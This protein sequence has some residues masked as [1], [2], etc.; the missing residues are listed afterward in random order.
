MPRRSK[1]TRHR[2]A[3]L[4]V[5]AALLAAC[6]SEALPEECVDEIRAAS[7][8]LSHD[9][10]AQMNG[11]MMNGLFL[12]G[13]AVN[14]LM[15]NGLMMNG[16]LLEG[17]VVNGVGLVSAQNQAGEVIESFSIQGED[18]ALR[19]VVGGEERGG[20]EAF[21]VVLTYENDQGQRSRLWIERAINL[22]QS[23]YLGGMLDHYELAY[24]VE[25]DGA[26]SE[27]HTDVCVNGAGESVPV[28]L[29]NGEWDYETGAWISEDPE[30]IT[31]ACREAAIAKCIEWS[32]REQY[33]ERG[34]SH[35]ACTRMVR[36]DYAGDGTP[37]TLNGTRIYVGDPFGYNDHQHSHPGW[38]V[39]EAEWTP[40]G[41]SCINR[42][43]LR[44]LGETDCASDPD[45]FPGVPECENTDILEPSSDTVLVTATSRTPFGTPDYLYG[46]Q[47]DEAAGASTLFMAAQDGSSYELIGTLTVAETVDAPKLPVEV[48]GLYQTDF[49]GL[50]GFQIDR[51][52]G[53]SRAVIVNGNATA[54]PRGKWHPDREFRAAA[55]SSSNGRRLAF[56]I[57]PNTDELC[58]IWALDGNIASSEGGCTTLPEDIADD[59]DLVET[60]EGGEFT[61]I[62]GG[63]VWTMDVEGAT[64][65][66]VA[67]LEASV[68]GIA[69]TA[70]AGLVG[71]DATGSQLVDLVVSESCGLAAG[72]PLVDVVPGALGDL[73]GS[74]P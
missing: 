52:R 43:G 17:G 24:E 49:E 50:M 48:D 9:N 21:P 13:V 46:V 33:G 18:R 47:Y 20:P 59:V 35:Q 31:M 26:W 45:C 69:R 29:V 12:N 8:R 61:V 6:G 65:Q 44:Q 68:V 73:A 38:L 37:H 32:Y 4:G 57:A 41:A 25:Q 28:L 2:A 74:A 22:G 72:A 16:A 66:R 58:R 60:G 67:T 19:Y 70:D 51:E 56:A 54:R 15:M 53:Q 64:L 3:V 7:F 55:I 40:D 39:K 71:L 1:M 63:R 11:L 27:K 14:G 30:T 62:E 36:A 42:S 10:S 23:A 5:S 34:W